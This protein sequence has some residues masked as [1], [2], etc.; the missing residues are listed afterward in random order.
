MDWE[1]DMSPVERL[2]REALVTD[3]ERHVYIADGKPI[4]FTPEESRRLAFLT[5]RLRRKQGVRTRT[6]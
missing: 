1:R 5:W 2:R 4:R 3:A 6:G